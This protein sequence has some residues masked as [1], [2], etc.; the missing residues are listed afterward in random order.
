MELIS[1]IARVENW[2]GGVAQPSADFWGDKM[3]IL[4][5]KYLYFIDMS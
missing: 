2:G 3:V 4:G 1:G 5:A